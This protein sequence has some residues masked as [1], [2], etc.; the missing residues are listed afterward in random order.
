MRTYSREDV[1]LG[2]TFALIAGA[3][4]SYWLV[5]APEHASASFAERFT[6]DEATTAAR[7]RPRRISVPS[8]QFDERYYPGIFAGVRERQ[9]Q[10]T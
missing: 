1:R 9:E 4:C 2:V 5:R 8:A 7:E 6:F 3:I 10:R